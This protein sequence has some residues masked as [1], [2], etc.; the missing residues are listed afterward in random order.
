[1]D[2][3]STVENV[4]DTIKDVEGVVDLVTE[5]GGDVVRVST[6]ILA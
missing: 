2:E 4:E 1:M 6:V 5:Q 3:K